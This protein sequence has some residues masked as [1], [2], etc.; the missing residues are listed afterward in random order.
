MW[1]SAPPDCYLTTPANGRAH[2]ACRFSSPSTVM[3]MSLISHLVSAWFAFLLPSFATYK[4]LARLPQSEPDVQR[5]GMYWSVVG[6]FVAFEYI[7]EW[8]ISWFPFYWECKTLFLLYLALPQTEGSTYIYQNYLRP[9]LA[10]N[11]AALDDGI[12]ALQRNA[13]GFIQQKLTDLLTLAANALNKQG[14]TQGHSGQPQQGANPLQTAAS[15]WQTYGGSLLGALQ[16]QQRSAATATGATQHPATTPNLTP[17]HSGA[18][19][20]S[21]PSA[22]LKTPTPPFPVPHHFTP[23]Q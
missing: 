7:A 14:N 2:R 22:E 17:R 19:N 6:A 20:A 13:F 4:A 21:S 3:F 16:Q 11:E 18:S 1:Y 10:K 5:W 9:F 15:L 12:V 8:F 23:S